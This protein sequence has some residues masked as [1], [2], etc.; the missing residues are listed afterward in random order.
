MGSFQ[1]KDEKCGHG[2]VETTNPICVRKEK[3]NQ[4]GIYEK[5]K[6]EEMTERQ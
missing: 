1:R 6:T 5:K 2:A 4:Q 3:A